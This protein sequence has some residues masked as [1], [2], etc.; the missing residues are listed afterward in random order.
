[1]T[2]KPSFRKAFTLIELL[3]VIAIIAILIGL[4]LPAV[5]KVREAANRV[6]CANHL[7]QFGTA[8]H[9]YDNN[10]DRLPV[11][12]DHWGWEINY[13]NMQGGNW[14]F[15]LLP[16]I[17]QQAVYDNA[18]GNVYN[19]RKFTSPIFKCPSDPSYGSGFGNHGTA[20]AYDSSPSGYLFCYAA[21]Y[22][23]FGNP[24]A[25]DTWQ[26]TN[27][28][29]R[30]GSSFTDGTSNTILVAER[31]ASCGPVA[32]FW[33]YTRQDPTAMPSFA[34]GNR[35][36]TA[37][38]TLWQYHANVGSVGPSSV[39]QIRPR[40]YSYYGPAL[41]GT[42]SQ[43]DPRRP[44]S[45]HTGGMQTLFGDASV[46]NVRASI[47]PNTWWAIVTPANGDIPGDY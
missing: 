46:R 23:V 14:V 5:Q 8:F 38:Y 43:C 1:M 35:A 30:I 41:P 4:L 32:Q 25:G 20:S 24:E 40:N 26:N 17:E 6:R 9:N 36:G 39:P 12:N 29:Y 3:V 19:A 2:S 21:N 15:Y 31:Y 37:G 28:N 42:A 44:S 10:N 45:P 11:M 34:F 33:F 47:D 7:K 13:L 22:Q 27:G 18:N 16:Y